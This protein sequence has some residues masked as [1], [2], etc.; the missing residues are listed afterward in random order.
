[1]RIS[2]IT[3]ISNEGIICVTSYYSYLLLSQ[4]YLRHEDEKE[5]TYDF[6]NEKTLSVKY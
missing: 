5:N 2:I 4:K 6:V 1:M 3:G